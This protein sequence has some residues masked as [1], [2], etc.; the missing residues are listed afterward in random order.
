M[1]DSAAGKGEAEVGHVQEKQRKW[2]GKRET[3][4][5]RIANRGD[6]LKITTSKLKGRTRGR[7]T[8]VCSGLDCGEDSKGYI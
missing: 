1:S 5:E 6:R 4:D 8:S 2:R 3:R 7:K